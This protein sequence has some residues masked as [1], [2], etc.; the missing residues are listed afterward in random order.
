M[1]SKT[2]ADV[3]L[4]EVSEDDWHFVERMRKRQKNEQVPRVL[5][6]LQV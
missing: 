3:V 4:D 1:I 2:A 5:P 6:S